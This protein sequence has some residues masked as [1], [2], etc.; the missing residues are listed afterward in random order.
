[1]TD[2]TEALVRKEVARAR[3]ILREDRVLEKLNKAYPDEAPEEDPNGPTPPAKQPPKE[4]PKRRGL[5]WGE[6]RDE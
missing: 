5:W 6:E 4:Q 1:M 3:K 2:P